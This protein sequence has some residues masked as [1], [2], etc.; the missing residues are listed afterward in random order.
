MIS[1]ETCSLV[2]SQ[3]TIRGHVRIQAHVPN[4]SSA[5]FKCMDTAQYSSF[6]TGQPVPLRYCMEAENQSWLK[7]LHMIS[8]GNDDQIVHVL[9]TR[10][11]EQ[12]A[13]NP[14][15]SQV[16]NLLPATIIPPSFI[17]H[18]IRNSLEH[19]PSFQRQRKWTE[20]H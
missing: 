14:V 10:A 3:R 20:I 15:I 6:L 9:Q 17:K 18:C 19:W 5:R 13:Y 16:P 12:Q 1:T 2:H 4:H 7:K 11:D 8:D